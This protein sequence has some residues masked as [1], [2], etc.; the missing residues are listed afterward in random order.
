MADEQAV[1]EWLRKVWE[2]GRVVYDVTMALD[3][4]ALLDAKDAERTRLVGL[5]DVLKIERDAALSRAEQAEQERD[6]LRSDVEDLREIAPR[7]TQAAIALRKRAE[8]AEAA[9]AERDAAIVEAHRRCTSTDY[10]GS[11]YWLQE[12]AEVLKPFL[13]AKPAVDPLIA[14]LCGELDISPDAAEKALANL[15][16]KGLIERAGGTIKFPDALLAQRS[17][18]NG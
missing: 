4:L 17:K 8:Q 16:A 2:G 1:R 14:T 11:R 3:S 9:L 18:T 5:L 10:R 6:E 7:G 12:V 13:P 15:E